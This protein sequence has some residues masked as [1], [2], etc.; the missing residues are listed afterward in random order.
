MVRVALVEGMEPK[1]D[2]KERQR[3]RRLLQDY[4]DITEEGIGMLFRLMETGAKTPSGKTTLNKLISMVAY[5]SGHWRNFDYEHLKKE[6]VIVT[7]NG[8]LKG[9]VSLIQEIDE[10]NVIFVPAVGEKA[11]APEEEPDYLKHID[12]R[13][14]LLLNGKDVVKRFVHEKGIELPQSYLKDGHVTTEVLNLLE[15]NGFYFNEALRVGVEVLKDEKYKERII[16]AMVIKRRDGT[17]LRLHPHD[18]VEAAEFYIY[19]LIYNKKI[20][21]TLGDKLTS[22][23]TKYHGA[24]FFQVPKRM[25][26][27]GK[28][29]NEV[30]LHYFPNPTGEGPYPLDWMSTRVACNCPH[31]LNMRNFEDRRGKM[32]RV[33][34]TMD[35]HANMVFLAWMNTKQ[36]NTEKAVNNMSPVPTIEFS[37]FVDKTRY[38][39]VQEFEIQEEDKTK[40]RR[41]YVG[42]VGI[43]KLIHELA[44]S[45]EWTFDRMFNPHEKVGKR[46]LRPMYLQ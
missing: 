30:E 3:Y 13:N 14:K 21:E 5:D 34:E 12:W 16:A 46:L 38:N 25:P 4:S 36:V 9:L 17:E 45:L 11:I 40:T 43:E 8:N 31:A 41:T 28:V 18:F 6:G 7:H 22:F 19:C 10:S 37:N 24:N 42:E 33:V 1:Y 44:K 27:K 2:D 23:G 35:T 20:V 26:I 39:L 32:T 15:Q 29:Y